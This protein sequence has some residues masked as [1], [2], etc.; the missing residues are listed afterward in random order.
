MLWLYGLRNGQWLPINGDMT[1]LLR[2]I[3][4]PLLAFRTST[5]AST[6]QYSWWELR[7]QPHTWRT[8]WCGSW[9]GSKAALGSITS[10]NITDGTHVLSSFLFGMGSH[11]QGS[12]DS[13]VEQL[14]IVLMNSHAAL[15]YSAPLGKE[16][17]KLHTH[18]LCVGED[19]GLDQWLYF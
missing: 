14:L 7:I 1:E 10:K 9:N 4:R 17:W 2:T 3:P 18:A 6:R 5:G 13:R 15:S 8:P 11:G 19:C 12:T 16:Q